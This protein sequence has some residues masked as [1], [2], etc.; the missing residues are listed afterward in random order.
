LLETALSNRVRHW[1]GRSDA[2]DPE[3]VAV[4]IAELKLPE[5]LC[6]LLVQRGHGAP[7]AARAF[8]KPRLEQLHDPFEMAGMQ[9]A[10][11]R[12]GHAIRAGERILVHGDY[13]V[14]GV[15]AAALLTR[16]L[17]KLGADVQPFVPNRL[18]DGY[19]LGHAG[20]RMAQQIGA[21][22]I[23]TGDCGI[24]AHEAVEAAAQLGVDVVVSDHHTP[25][26]ELPPALAVLNPRRNDC[27][28]PEK[29]LAGSGVA[30]KLCQALVQRRGL[31]P[32]TAY[33]H[34]DLVGMATIADVVPLLG[35]NRI[36]ARYGLQVLAQTGNRGLD[37]L[38]RRAG[39]RD[40]RRLLAGHV[41]HAIGPRINAIGRLDEAF[42]AVKLLIS[43][44]EE[45]LGELVERLE[46]SN[47]ERQ[48]LDRQT[49]QGA[50][51][52][53]KTEYQ[54][55][56]DHAVVLAAR[57]WH[58]GVIGIVASR[59]VELIHRPTV[60][61]ALDDNGGI[62]R[63]SA[64]SI[65]GFHLYDAL[66]S[67]SRHLLRFG[68]HHHAAGMDILA[69]E[70]GP[71]REAFLEHAASVLDRSQLVPKLRVDVEIGLVEA[72][73][74]LYRMLRHMGPFGAG[75]PEPVFVSRGVRVVGYPRVVGEEHV[76]LDL[77]QDGVRLKAIGFR[78]ADRLR[79]VDVSRGPIDI[80]YQL[81]EDQYN[82]RTR[83]QARLVDLREA[84]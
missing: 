12:I 77:V 75:N 44:R 82:G 83:L 63:G 71:F 65:P 67:C 78:M 72:N 3:A 40:G 31:E 37:A 80:A 55:E 56:R 8:L 33:A 23:V 27:R 42:L 18:T 52:L 57:G 81:Q 60:L 79:E 7:D 38:L 51:A 43:E 76:K 70:V 20:L 26:P 36:L 69:D 32:D 30:F 15:C 9:E 39:L 48:Q 53:L 29:S 11:D 61:I 84:G 6:R 19:D 66:R 49:L 64:R 28:Y 50:V 24:V 74:E 1:T 58:R 10:V 35:E 59:I 14:D 47:Q 21:G 5:P 13:D 17:R 2:V 25:G 22:L 54:P 34:L 68:G 16:V 62:A 46:S 41:S 73:A 45:E 4:L